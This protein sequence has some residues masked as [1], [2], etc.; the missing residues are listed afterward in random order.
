MGIYVCGTNK[1]LESLIIS[2]K[3]TTYS[4]DE[5]A[6]SDESKNNEIVDQP[7]VCGDITVF[8]QLCLQYLM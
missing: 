4:D 6:Y 7:T 8:N 2:F 3:R 5:T 1:M